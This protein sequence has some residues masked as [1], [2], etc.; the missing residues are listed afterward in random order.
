[1]DGATGDVGTFFK[2]RD[3]RWVD[4]QFT[5]LPGTVHHVTIPS[6]D[7][8]EDSFKEGFGKLDGSSI[9]GFNAVPVLFQRVRGVVM[10]HARAHGLRASYLV[11]SGLP[12][13]SAPGPCAPVASSRIRRKTSAPSPSTLRTSPETK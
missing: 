7:F 6:S 5:D 1:M 10:P 13:G 11:R 8:T 12:Y 4:L 2:E 9:R 3:I